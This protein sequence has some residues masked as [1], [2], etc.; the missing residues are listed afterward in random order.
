[1]ILVK[2]ILIGSILFAAVGV[3]AACWAEGEGKY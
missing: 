3:A 1:M 2:I